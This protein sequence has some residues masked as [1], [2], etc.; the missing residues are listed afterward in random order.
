MGRLVN[1]RKDP[2]SEYRLSFEN[3]RNLMEKGFDAN[4]VSM[5]FFYCLTI[6]KHKKEK[7]K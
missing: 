2:E 3:I 7:T 1:L 5:P 4:N 6:I